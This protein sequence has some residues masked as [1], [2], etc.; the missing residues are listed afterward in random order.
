MCWS[1]A[2]SLWSPRIWTYPANRPRRC[3]PQPVSLPTLTT[4]II[5]VVSVFWPC[6]PAEDYSGLFL[7]GHIWKNVLDPFEQQTYFWRFKRSFVFLSKKQKARLRR[8]FDPDWGV[9]AL[10]QHSYFLPLTINQFVIEYFFCTDVDGVH[11]SHPFHLIFCFEFFRNALLHSYLILLVEKTFPLFSGLFR[12]NSCSAC[13]LAADRY[14]FSLMYHRCRRSH[15]PI[16]ANS[17]MMRL[18]R[19]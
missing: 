13:R 8:A 15:M 5:A 14:R 17:E 11:L 4:V 7:D 18:E 19:R 9:L 6:K 12:P 10:H 16:E 3:A 1:S 2:L